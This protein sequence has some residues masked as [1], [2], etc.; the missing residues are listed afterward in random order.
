M[1]I[2]AIEPGSPASDNSDVVVGLALAS[3]NGAA[4]PEGGA[5]ILKRAWQ[6]LLLEPRILLEF[7]CCVVK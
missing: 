5:H 4:L 6:A 7:S 1:V 3:V 2:S